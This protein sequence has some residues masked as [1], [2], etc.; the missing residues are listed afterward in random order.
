MS[1]FNLPGDSVRILSDSKRLSTDAKYESSNLHDPESVSE[2][3][4]S[5]DDL[6]DDDEAGEDN[7]SHPD[8]E[9]PVHQKASNYGQD[10]IG[11]AIP[12]VEIGELGGGYVETCLEF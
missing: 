12:G 7:C 4:K 9:D 1:N 5:E 2:A 8:A 6:A 3:S 11:P 10:S